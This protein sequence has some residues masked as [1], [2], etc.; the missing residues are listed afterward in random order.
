MKLAQGG[1]EIPHFLD[2]QW[3]KFQESK[4]LTD[5]I[6]GMPP[7]MAF[8]PSF[9]RRRDELGRSRRPQPTTSPSSPTSAAPEAATTAAAAAASTATA[10]GGGGRASQQ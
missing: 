6:H 1:H 8:L 4:N 5:V 2:E 10:G 9:S 7:K 3:K